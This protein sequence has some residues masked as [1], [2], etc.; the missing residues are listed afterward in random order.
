MGKTMKVTNRIL[1]LPMA[2][3]FNVDPAGRVFAENFLC[4]GNI[5]NF[6]VGK[7][8]FRGANLRK[9]KLDI[10][11]KAIDNIDE[12]GNEGLFKESSK[13]QKSAVNDEFPDGYT[14]THH[15]IFGLSGNLNEKDLR[16]Y[17]FTADYRHFHDQL[18]VLFH[19]V[20][21]AMSKKSSR[22][23]VDSWFD[24]SHWG[25]MGISFWVEGAS[26][27]S[28]SISNDIGETSRASESAQKSDA[29]REAA[30]LS[31][32][33]TGEVV[34]M[35]GNS[36]DAVGNDGSSLASRAVSAVGDGV[37]AA[38]RGLAW[39]GHKITFGAFKSEKVDNKEELGERIMFPK[40]W[41]NSTYDKSYNLSFR[42]ISPYGD[43]D[44]IFQFV[45][46]PFLIL[47]AMALP[48]QYSAD[49]YGSPPLIRI[50]A[51]GNFCCDMGMIS[52]MSFTKGTSQELW[53]TKGF[54]LGIDVT[55]NIVDMYP[56]LSCPVN[57]SLLKQN[58]GMSTMLQTMS[59]LSLMQANI[60][61]N[62]KAFWQGK[63]LPFFG[64]TAFGKVNAYW[65][66]FVN[67]L[68]E[69]FGV[70]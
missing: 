6:V 51:P 66:D 67:H 31:G 23:N 57:D 48:K 25:D 45:Y 10:L 21:S 64:G 37:K 2:F 8:A 4:N 29:A 9:E 12:N 70:S 35:K 40:M 3:P 18:N 28:E 47:L 33:S 16:Y 34:G 13:L 50:D 5:V 27:C 69:P 39:L 46:A 55:I 24:T 19:Y 42:F 1:G 41:K 54:P 11:N 30:F 56:S 59:G 58:I 43:P 60:G 65:K 7:P 14:K 20:G 49:S 53:S 52:S 36:V 68:S 15:G 38:G 32:K 63:V 22:N 61:A 26:Q 62:M 17:S 44:S